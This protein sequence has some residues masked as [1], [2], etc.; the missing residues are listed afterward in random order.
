MAPLPDLDLLNP[1]YGVQPTGPFTTSLDVRLLS[2]WAGLYLQETFIP[3]EP[4]RIVLAGRATFI[5]T[6]TENRLRPEFS[7]SPFD[8]ALTP[9]LGVVYTPLRPVSLFA[10]YSTSFV[11][12][13]GATFDGKAFVPEEGVSYEA[14]VKTEF[15]DGR[16]SS[17][18]AVFSMTRENVTTRDPV[19]TT[20]SVQTGEQ[21]SRG[22]EWELGGQPLPGWNSTAAFTWLDTELTKDNVFL[23]GQRTAGAPEYS[24]SLWTTYTI[25]GGP[26]Q[27][28]GGGFGVFYEG[29]R[30]GQ[31]VTT[32]ADAF[33]LPGYAR[34]DIALFY[35][36]KGYELRL[37]INNVTDEGYFGGNF[38]RTQVFPGEPFNVTGT[39]RFK[40]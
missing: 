9:R 35:Q 2:Q 21:R 18:L 34:G 7:G 38:G 8:I 23:V 6:E 29:E 10:S 27:G 14:G 13:V 11:P 25:Q 40:F 22:V 19:N 33:E 17:T 24:A 39:L 36:Q 15:W 30:H 31:L 28:L 32:A 4:L 16:L 5:E 12:H 20:F 37:N 1:V 3:W 26:L